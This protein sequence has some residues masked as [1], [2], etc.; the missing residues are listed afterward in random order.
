MMKDIS[1]E[2]SAG[3]VTDCIQKMADGIGSFC[4]QGYKLG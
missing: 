4:P 3:V 2:L 1:K